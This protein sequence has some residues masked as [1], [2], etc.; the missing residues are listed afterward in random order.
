VAE[1]VDRF[2]GPRGLARS[3]V[4]TMME[5]LREKGHLRRRREGGSFRYRSAVALPELLRRLVGSF[6]DKSLDGSVSPF[7]NYL[8]ER[9]EVSDRELGELEDLVDRLKA[10]REED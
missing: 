2:G 4:L 8:A 1:A 10:R 9:A 6:V 3:T 7:V 5:R